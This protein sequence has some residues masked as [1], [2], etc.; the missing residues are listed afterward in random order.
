MATQQGFYQHP[1]PYIAGKQT[2]QRATAR[3]AITAGAIAWS[4][5]VGAS[6]GFIHADG[7][8]VTVDEAIALWELY[9][10]GEIRVSAAGTVRF[11][12]EPTE[13]AA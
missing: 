2:W 3:D 4:D 11:A 9:E 12:D 7:T 8:R 5:K 10:A 13:M 6:G 1:N